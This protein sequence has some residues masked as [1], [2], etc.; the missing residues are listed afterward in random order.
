MKLLIRPSQVDYADFADTPWRRLAHFTR[1][2]LLDGFCDPFLADDESNCRLAQWERVKSAHNWSCQICT[3]TRNEST[4]HR[5]SSIAKAKNVR[6]DFDSQLSGCFWPVSQG[7]LRIGWLLRNAT[8]F[9]AGS[10]S[11]IVVP[12]TIGVFCWW[13]IW[14]VLFSFF[15]LHYLFCDD[16]FCIPLSFRSATV[17]SCFCDSQA[18][19]PPIELTICSPGYSFFFGKQSFDPIQV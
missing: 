12:P 19:H 15:F 5:R 11:G 9:Q 7:N 8:Q 6:G 1:N 18:F 3:Q 10:F 17:G 13:E 16:T 2:T 4:P 14:H